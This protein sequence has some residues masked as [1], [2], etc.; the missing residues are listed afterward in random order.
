MAGVH[1]IE[2]ITLFLVGALYV[3]KAM[4]IVNSNMTA[5][6]IDLKN[7][8]NVAMQ[9]AVYP[10]ISSI[11]FVILTHFGTAKESTLIVNSFENLKLIAY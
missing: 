8:V 5:P 2:F 1:L 3:Q 11:I 10:K 4:N 9:N 6:S 7:E